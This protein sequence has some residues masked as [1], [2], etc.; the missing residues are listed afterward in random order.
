[1]LDSL[2]FIAL[3]VDMWLGSLQAHDA[4]AQLSHASGRPAEAF[5]HLREAVKVQSLCSDEFRCV[6][7]AVDCYRHANCC[8]LITGIPGPK[9]VSQTCG[10]AVFSLS[11]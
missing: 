7:C 2:A 4:V 11:F 8:S 6:N 5:H 1:M 9:L 3:M 10:G